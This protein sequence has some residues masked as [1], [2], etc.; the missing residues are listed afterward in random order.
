MSVAP[1]ISIPRPDPLYHIVLLTM[2]TGMLVLAPLLSVREET[3]V[4]VP[5]LGTPLPELCMSKRTLGMSCPGCGMTRCF[6]SLAHGDLASAWRY[7]PAGPLLFAMVAAQIPFRLVQLY[8]IR[9]GRR[10]L[11]VGWLT[12]VLMSVLGVLMV[13]QWLLRMVGF[14]F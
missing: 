14:T 8:R 1:A 3:Q 11:Q 10:E 4:L 2:C 7:N 6:I 12:P 5:L 9:R 13:G